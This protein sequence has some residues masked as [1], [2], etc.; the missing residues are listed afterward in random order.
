MV[1]N[2]YYMIKAA[3][4]YIVYNAPDYENDICNALE[5]V[6]KQSLFNE[7]FVKGV[8]NEFFRL[9]NNNN[10]IVD[11]ISEKAKNHIKNM[12]KY[13][14]KNKIISNKYLILRSISFNRMI[15]NDK[16]L[17]DMSSKELSYYTEELKLTDYENFLKKHLSSLCKSNNSDLLAFTFE[18]VFS[19]KKDINHTFKKSLFVSIYNTIPPD[20]EARINQKNLDFIGDYVE[21]LSKYVVMDPEELNSEIKEAENIFYNE[22]KDESSSALLEAMLKQKMY[23]KNIEMVNHMLNIQYQKRILRKSTENNISGIQH[24]IKSRL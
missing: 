7:P 15:R 8:V 5:R 11:V 22:T 12:L 24:I 1:E 3:A 20:N 6:G 16:F 17:N 18:K 19:E 13:K 9:K 21:C 14:R 23:Q 4:K 10:I 2:T